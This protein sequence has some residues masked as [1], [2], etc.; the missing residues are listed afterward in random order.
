MI[1]N[2]FTL[3]SAAAENMKSKSKNLGKEIKHGINK[4]KSPR[5]I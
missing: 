4:R 1:I 2:W 5:H 3:L